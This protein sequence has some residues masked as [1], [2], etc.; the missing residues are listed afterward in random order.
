MSTEFCYAKRNNVPVY[1][2]E[3]AKKPGKPSNT[4]MLGTY[5]EILQ[6]SAAYLKIEAFKKEYWINKNDTTKIN[7]SLKLFFVDVGQGDGMLVEVGDLKIIVDGGKGK[8]LKSF[9]DK[10]KYKYLLDENKKIEIDYLFITHLDED[11]FEGLIDIFTDPGY[12]FKKVYF[13]GLIKFPKGKT[14]NLGNTIE[15]QK[16]TYVTSVIPDIETIAK[17]DGVSALILKFADAYLSSKGRNPSLT[18]QRISADDGELLN[19]NINGIN[20]K[21]EILGPVLSNVNSKKYFK[22]LSD[23]SKTI[24]G[25]SLILKIT[26]GTRTILLGGDLNEEFEKHII[27]NHK[28][29]NS[30]DAE[31]YKCGHHGSRDFSVEFLNLIKPIATVISSGDNESYDHP[32]ALALGCAGKYSR[33]LNPLVFSTELARSYNSSKFI[34]GLIFY[35]TNGTEAYFS[36][37]KEKKGTGNPFAIYEL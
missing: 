16:E 28:S 25:H 10:W 4:L 30:F 6:E 18:S 36:Q 20:F 7:D 32:S 11:H 21:I 9:L 26:Y 37:M 24:N 34:Y 12:I 19:Q 31:V 22:W 17:T 2:K 35:R 14:F 3:P 1:S 27:N 33:S 15:C 8:S 5:M 29:L 13:A 23:A